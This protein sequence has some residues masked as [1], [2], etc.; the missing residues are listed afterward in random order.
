MDPSVSIIGDLVNDIRRA[1][2]RLPCLGRSSAIASTEVS[3]R[4]DEYIIRQRMYIVEA[5]L[6]MDYSGVER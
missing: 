3:E 2:I 1:D 4:G 6:R 5:I